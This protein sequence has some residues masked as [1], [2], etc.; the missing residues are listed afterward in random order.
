MTSRYEVFMDEI[1][2]SSVNPQILIEDIQ[3]QPA[4]IANQS[5]MSANRNGAIITR[6]YQEKT[7]VT[8]IFSVNEYNIVKRQ[9]ILQDIV[10]WARGSI[11]ETNDREGQMLRCICDNFPSL[12][13]VKNWT[14]SMSMTFSAYALPLLFLEV[15]SQLLSLQN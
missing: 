7:S 13:S 2:L 5:I 10:K 3:Y 8:I 9:T 11:L 14:E 1:A 4:E 6:R 15:F 12:S